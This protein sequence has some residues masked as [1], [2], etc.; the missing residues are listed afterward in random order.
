MAQSE[1]RSDRVTLKDVAERAGVSLATASKVMNGRADVRQSTRETVAQAARDLGYEPKRRETD[2]RRSALIHFDT[3]TSPYSLQVLEGAE[4]A[5][6][7]ACVDLLVISGDQTDR[8]STR[9]W[10][11]DAASRAGE[12]VLLVTTPIGAQHARDR[13]SV[14]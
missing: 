14:V 6:H 8:K 7:R 10:M 2:G 12:G 13:K 5:A 11:A 1:P 9:A 4:Q 3:L